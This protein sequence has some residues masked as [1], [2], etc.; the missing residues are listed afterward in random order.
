MTLIY[1][2]DAVFEDTFSKFS[3]YLAELG[4][5]LEFTNELNPGPGLWSIVLKD[6]RSSIIT[7]NGKG[8]TLEAAKASALGEMAERFLN[9]AFLKI[10]G[11]EMP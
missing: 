2:K 5:D 10:T 8:A 7:T 4:L 11:L 1:G 3:K 6:K 9:Q